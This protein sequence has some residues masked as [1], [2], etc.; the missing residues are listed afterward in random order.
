MH[1]GI[2]PGLAPNNSSLFFPP[3]PL[4]TPPAISPKQPRHVASVGDAAQSVALTPKKVQKVKVV[5][6]IKSSKSDQKQPKRQ[7]QQQNQLRPAGPPPPK[8][9][10]YGTYHRAKR[11]TPEVCQL[12]DCR[13]GGVDV[14][15]KLPLDR[16]KCYY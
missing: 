6:K 7:Q 12:P 14:P 3:S 11:C 8:T 4:L 10:Q 16:Q 15:G 13:C 5:K 1:F 9:Y 2:V